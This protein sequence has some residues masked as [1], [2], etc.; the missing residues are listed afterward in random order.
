LYLNDSHFL[1]FKV[2]LGRGTD[3]YVEL[4]ALKLTLMHVAEKCVQF[5]NYLVKFISGYQLDAWEKYIRK[6]H[7]KA[8]I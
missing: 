5:Y 8:H 4:M 6:F 2:G 7:V 3:N 1:K